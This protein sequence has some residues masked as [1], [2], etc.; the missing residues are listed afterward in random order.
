MSRIRNRS[1][2]L[3]LLIF[4]VL[5][6]MPGCEQEKTKM[7]YTLKEADKLPA[8]V[9]Q[10]YSTLIDRQYIDQDY[11]MIQQET[12]TTTFPQA[13]Q[14]M[15]HSDTTGINQATIDRY[16]HGNNFSKNLGDN[17]ETQVMVRR[18][19]REEFDSYESWDRFHEKYP[20]A[21][22][23]IRLSLPGLNEDTTKAVFDYAW[24]TGYATVK[25]YLVFFEYRDGEWQ[26]DAHEPV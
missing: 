4:F 17:F 14:Q 6:A 25:N 20:G 13:C 2:R 1:G 19:T 22:G 26:M 24:H 12:D 3:M 15:L 10:V 7:V 8:E 18:I 21:E 23:L 16:L 5:S 11:V 9:Y